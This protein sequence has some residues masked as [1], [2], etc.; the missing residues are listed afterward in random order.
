VVKQAIRTFFSV[1]PDSLIGQRL[2]GPNGNPR[3]RWMPLYSLVWLCWLFASPLLAPPGTFP[4]WLWPTLISFAAFLPLY[5]CAQWRSI[6]WLIPVSLGIALLGYLLSPYNPGACCYIIYACA[7][8]A[9][10]GTMLRALALMLCVLL[11]FAEM[12][13]ARGLPLPFVLSML[14]M[15]LAV[16]ISNMAFRSNLVKDAQLQQSHDEIR[17]LAATAERERI[18]RDL[19]DLLGHTLSLIAL[20]S[21]LAGKLIARDAVAARREIADVERITREALAQVRSA[22]SGM[23]GAGLIGEVAS[24]RLLLECA[25]V[26]FKYT[27]FDRGLPPAQETCL[28]LALREAVTNIQRHAHATNAEAGLLVDGAAIVLFVRDDGKGGIGAHGNGLN[29]MRERVEALGGTLQV[30]AQRGQ[31]TRLTVQL[32]FATVNNVIAMPTAASQQ[33]RA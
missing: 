14:V 33:A 28:A 10:S 4:H 31:G 24:A 26:K 15:G 30:D 23:R 22:V 17:R 3:M 20:K 21:E 19:H 27:G 2:N 29:G 6:D 11:P 13:Y 7:Y 12:T 32:P 8:L 16:G 25:S 9:F 18:G 1:G 5:L